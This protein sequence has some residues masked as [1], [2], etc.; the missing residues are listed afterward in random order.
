[1]SENINEIILSKIFN[2]ELINN[3][4]DR[5]KNITKIK[6]IILLYKN[7]EDKLINNEKIEIE[8]RFN[9]KNDDKDV[10]VNIDNILSNNKQII[11]TEIIK[12]EITT[13]KNKNTRKIL[14]K[15]K[16]EE[17][18]DIK[19]INMNTEEIKNMLNMLFK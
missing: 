13:Y 19:I 1:M 16:Q 10:Y 17:N 6:N 18:E 11:K 7:I 4:K 15:Y 5:K 8:L 14:R 3:K 12:K 9:N 2:D